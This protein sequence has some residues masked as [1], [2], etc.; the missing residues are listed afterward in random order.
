MCG[1]LDDDGLDAEV[2]ARFLLTARRAGARAAQHGHVPD[3]DGGEGRSAYMQSLFAAGLARAMADAEAAT[4]GQRIEAVAAQAIAFARL[5]GFIAGQLPPE[6]DLF[7]ACIEALSDGHAE[8]RRIA[9]AER[10]RHIREHGHDHDEDGHHH[11]GDH[12]GHGHD[13]HG[14][15]HHGEH[16]HGGADR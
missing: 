7:R 5:A 6:A 1:E 9:E 8:P 11:H 4:E 2:L 14:H 13:H 16:R 15:H 12:H 10:Q 3:L